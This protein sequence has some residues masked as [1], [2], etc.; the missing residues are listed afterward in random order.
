MFLW[1][2][3]QIQPLREALFMRALSVLWSVTTL[4]CVPII[5]DLNVLTAQTTASLSWSVT[6]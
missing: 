1:Y 3:Y 6:L 2:E 4:E 5:N